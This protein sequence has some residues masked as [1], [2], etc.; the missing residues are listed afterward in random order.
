MPHIVPRTYWNSCVVLLKFKFNW[1]SHIEGAVPTFNQHSVE[2]CPPSQVGS[3]GNF[4]FPNFPNPQRHSLLS[5][6]SAGTIA[7]FPKESYLESSWLPLP[8]CWSSEETCML[9]TVFLWRFH[10][11]ITKTWTGMVTG[12]ISM[13]KSWNF[14]YYK[15][16]L[17]FISCFLSSTPPCLL[18]QLHP[19]SFLAGSRSLL[20]VMLKVPQ[21]HSPGAV[22]SFEEWGSF[23]KYLPLLSLNQR[24]ATSCFCLTSLHWM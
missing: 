7:W 2:L 14:Q 15:A 18:P 4:P 21:P 16:L 23:V 5:F 10:P 24:N 17:V 12:V 6:P 19:N 20:R 13:K 1:V 22:F 11:I 3:S 9:S 8:F